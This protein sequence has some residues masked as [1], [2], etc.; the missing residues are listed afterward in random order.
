MPIFFVN[1]I[2]CCKFAA[3]LNLYTFFY[4]NEEDTYDNISLAENININD[5][6]KNNNN[7][8]N[9]VSTSVSSNLTKPSSKLQLNLKG[10]ADFN[11]E[12]LE[13]YNDFS[14]SWRKEA[15]RMLMRGKK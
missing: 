10:V 7:Y 9:Y 1:Q 8:G 11:Q 4:G 3:H 12:F 13:N 5:N 15:D 2:K 14:P 6:P